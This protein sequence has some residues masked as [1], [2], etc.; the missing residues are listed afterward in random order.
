MLHEDDLDS[1]DLSEVSFAEPGEDDEGEEGDALSN[2]SKGLRNL[3]IKDTAAQ[4]HINNRVSSAHIRRHSREPTPCGSRIHALPKCEE[5]S[6]RT[7][8]SSVEHAPRG[9]SRVFPPKP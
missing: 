5:E 8:G 7:I 1:E 9:W 4:C 2:L 3:D 6:T